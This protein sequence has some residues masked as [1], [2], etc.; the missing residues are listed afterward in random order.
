MQWAVTKLSPCNIVS[1]FGLAAAT[2]L[3]EMYD[4]Y[5]AESFLWILRDEL[6]KNLVTISSRRR[7]ITGFAIPYT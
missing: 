7:L 3:F 5:E 4:I 2:A 6:V 1:L